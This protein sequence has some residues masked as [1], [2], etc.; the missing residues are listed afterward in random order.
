MSNPEHAEWVVVTAIGGIALVLVVGAAFA[1]LARRLGQPAVIGEI[2]A[3]ICL[4]PSLLG[5]LPGDLPGLFFPLEV[6]PY[7]GVVAQVGLLLFMFTIGWEFD[8]TSLRGRRR[9]TGTVWLSAA[10]TPMLLGVGLAALLFGT[11]GTVGGRDIDFL[12][13]ALFLGTAM[14]IAAFPVLAR[15]ITDKRLHLSRV[16]SLALALAALDDVLAWCL[17]AVVVAL[18]TAS[19]AAGFLG[20]IGWGAVYVIVMLAVVRPVL[21]AL[22]ARATSATTPWLA[23][24]AAAGALASAYVTSEIG[25][26][27][28]FGAFFFGLVMPRRDPHEL[29]R[30]GALVP[31]EHL[32]RMLLPLFFVVTGLS[33]DL[34]ALS[35]TGALHMALII[36]VAC[37]GKLGGVLVSARLNGMGW[38]ESTVL[39]LLMN[40]RGL[41]ELVILNVGLGLGLLS[42]ELFTALVMMALVTTAMTAPLLSWLLRRGLHEAGGA[43]G[44]AARG[45]GP[46]TS[47]AAAPQAADADGADAL[48]GSTAS[49]SQRTH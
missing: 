35:A 21:A 13:F 22:A 11:Y 18:V 29:L 16:G 30:R 24:L 47:P 46:V 7:L 34:T 41:T 28:I 36:V 37:V 6:R 49:K 45:T 27:A 31:I 25:L 2:T 1:A 17:L 10:V 20:V 48:V 44:A 8:H 23:A 39:G 42:T 32:S 40:T 38:R 43:E 26:H 15:I 14:S 9:T 4:G 5:L 33:V 12:D 19:G 3:G